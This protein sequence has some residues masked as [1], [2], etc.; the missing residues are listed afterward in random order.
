MTTLGLR[1]KDSV[2]SRLMA[3]FDANPDEE[4][5]IG[6]AAVKLDVSHVAVHNAVA[7]LS[8][9]GKLERANVVRIPG[10]RRDPL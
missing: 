5:T 1:R 10:K 4:L 2:S 8:R 9:D 6:Q 3:F 7:Q